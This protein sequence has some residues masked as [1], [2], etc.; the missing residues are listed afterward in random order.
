MYTYFEFQAQESLPCFEV[1]DLTNN[2]TGQFSMEE[3]IQKLSKIE[4]VNL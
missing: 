2:T 3:T 1:Q 4:T